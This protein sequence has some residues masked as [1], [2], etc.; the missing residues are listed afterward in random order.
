ME[1][2][3]LLSKEE[4]TNMDREKPTDGPQLTVV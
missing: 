2:R 3:F 1:A 4:G